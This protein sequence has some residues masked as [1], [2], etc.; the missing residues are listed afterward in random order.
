MTIASTLIVAALSSAT[1]S[2]TGHLLFP[3]MHHTYSFCRCLCL[4]SLSQKC[5]NVEVNPLFPF[6]FL[7]AVSSSC[8]HTQILTP[9][10]RPSVYS[11]Q[12][13]WPDQWEFPIDDYA[14]ML[15]RPQFSACW[16]GLEALLKAMLPSANLKWFSHGLHV[17]VL[18]ALGFHR[19]TR[20]YVDS[21]LLGVF[22][23]VWAGMVVGGCESG[24]G[25]DSKTCEMK[26]K[27]KSLNLTL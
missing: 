17:R 5:G 24:F 11:V 14:G 12:P 10:R 20:S 1:S 16:Q 2:H 27:T 3:M 21:L 8:V 9:V 23:F 15:G 25:W 19:L 4:I 13:Q 22:S 7:L 18:Q 6:V 26:N